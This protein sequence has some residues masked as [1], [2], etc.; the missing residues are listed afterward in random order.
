MPFRIE[1]RILIGRLLTR[2]G[3]QAWDFAVPIVLLK[4]LP[5]HLRIAAL[6]YLLIRLATVI[7]LPRVASIID[8]KDR[9]STVKIGLG[10]QFVGV[11]LGTIGIFLISK[12]SFVEPTFSDIQF[13]I[14]FSFLVFGG[15]VGALGASLMDIAIAN[16]LAPT[17]FS[18][19]QLIR[20]NGHFR[21]VDLLT[22]VGAPIVAGLLLAL[23]NPSFALLGFFLIAVWNLLSFFP[24]FMILMS[25]FRDRP[26][27]EAKP[28]QVAN[29][30]SQPFL[31]KLTSGWRA[32]FKEPIAPAM[33]A[34]AF[35][36]LS[37]LSPH[38][39]LLTGFLQDGWQ[40]PEWLIGTFRGSGAIF[41]LAATFLFPFVAK[42][43]GIKIASLA[44][45]AFQACMVFFAF[46]CFLLGDPFGQLAFL[47]LILLSRIGVYGFTLGEMQ[48]RQEGIAPATRGQ[49]NGFAS[50]LT[51]VATLVL[52]GA[53]ATLPTTNDFRYLVAMSVI[54][55]FI[56][57]VTFIFWMRKSSP[58]LG[59][60]GARPHIAT[61]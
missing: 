7:L 59:Y 61:K 44:F 49:V 19:E 58:L 53:G 48:I 9:K 57:L 20:F 46:I 35:L 34:H 30:V 32:F 37:V 52:F 1:T 56:A 3:D 23:A 8:V 54:C 26:D 15:T 10:V 60:S 18:G 14:L 13:S 4:L 31:S 24:E 21:Q 11:L 55:V 6:F 45:L 36:W 40:L 50:A 51:G 29:A 27:L 43:V 5:G 17:V 42:K 47:V 28:I 33:I 12:H 41:G 16:D 2:S 22:E 39:V 38:G 25:V